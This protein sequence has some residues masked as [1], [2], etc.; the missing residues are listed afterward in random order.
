M[1]CTI[2]F[3][4]VT[5]SLS[6]QSVIKVPEKLEES[7]ETVDLTNQDDISLWEQNKDATDMFDNVRQLCINICV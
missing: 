2:S 7:H 3:I 1:T 4:A 5:L 6:L